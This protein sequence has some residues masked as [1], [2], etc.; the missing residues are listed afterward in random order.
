MDE[1]AEEELKSVLLLEARI[2]GII[3]TI[4]IRVIKI[5]CFI[6]RDN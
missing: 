1:E 3:I 2:L 4:K 5:R 6:I